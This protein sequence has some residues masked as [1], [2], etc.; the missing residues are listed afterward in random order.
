MDKIKKT[1]YAIVDSGVFGMRIVSGIVTGIQFT[2]GKPRYSV[3]FGANQW[4]T[5]KIAEDKEELL[6]LLELP[7]LDEVRKKNDAQIKF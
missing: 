7:K 2:E 1:V 5:T 3:V 4:W 6:E